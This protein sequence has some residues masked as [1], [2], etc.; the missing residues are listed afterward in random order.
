MRSNKA[1]KEHKRIFVAIEIP[2]E[3]RSVLAVESRRFRETG[4]YVSWV[5]PENMHLTLRFYGEVNAQQLSCIIKGLANGCREY[6]QLKLA[7]SGLGAFPKSQ[8]PAVIW[9]GVK[10]L[11]GDIVLIQSITEQVAL[12]AGLD[13]EKKPFH[14]H[15][16]LGRV[17][18]AAHAVRLG[19]IL[20]KRIDAG[21]LDF[22][23]EFEVQSMAL[24]ES[25]L[26]PDGPVYTCL[27]EFPIGCRSSKS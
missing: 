16:T 27:E 7:V 10:V 15:I 24:W 6:S 17:R 1:T 9:A 12:K 22:G 14:P 25:E 21:N 3:I 5:N 19:E 4:G 11:T 20:A 2:Y 18:N 13:P 23:D 26:R 8:R